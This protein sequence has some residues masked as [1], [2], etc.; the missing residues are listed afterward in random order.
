[1]L[2]L[3]PHSGP[4]TVPNAGQAVAF[5]QEGGMWLVYFTVT[6][7]GGALEAGSPGA[8]LLWVSSLFA[9]D[10]TPSSWQGDPNCQTHP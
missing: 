5:G 4:F 10:R 9:E 1:M 8:Y 7:V 2:T 6:C 3:R